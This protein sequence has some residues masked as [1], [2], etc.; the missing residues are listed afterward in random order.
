MK[1]KILL[2]A[3]LFI[4][5]SVWAETYTVERVIDG[6]TLKL[7]NGETIQ[8]IGINAPELIDGGSD[9]DLTMYDPSEEELDD[10][11]QFGV[12]IGTMAKM[13]QEA[14]EFLK[15]YIYRGKEIILEFDVQERDGYGRLLAYVYYNQTI[16]ITRVPQGL[17]WD[18]EKG[19][20]INATLIKSGYAQPMTIPPNVKYAELFEEL[21]K[22]AREQKRGLWKKDSKPQ[23]EAFYLK[24]GYKINPDSPEGLL[25]TS[26]IPKC[27]AQVDGLMVCEGEGE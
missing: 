20:F 23:H 1:K 26:G 4:S 13:G 8:L 14:T 18:P 21:Y 24:E 16:D 5:T 17:H 15:R 2:I 11:R 7:T 10:M 22:E 3:I 9:I 25:D 27:K 6:G 19:I 12:N